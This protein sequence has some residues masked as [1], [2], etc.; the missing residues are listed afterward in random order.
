MNKI[1]TKL[2]IIW[3]SLLCPLFSM[4]SCSF[5][6]RTARK[7]LQEAQKHPYDIIVVP[8]VPFEKDTWSR[9]MKGRVYWSKYLFDQGIAK[10]IMYSGSSVYSPYFE[11]EIMALYAEALGI[12]KQY[13]Y[14]ETKAEHS[15]ENIYY[16]YRRSIQLGF[17]RIALASDPFQTKAL[18]KFTRKK[19]SADIGLIP[20][21]TDTLKAMEPQ[22][23]DPVIDYRQAY[24]K[25][26]VPLTEREG[27][28]K[29]LRGTRGLNIDTSA[30]K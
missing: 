3:P 20:M 7:L 21:T 18:R 25:D 10:N 5:S 17:H 27:F 14:T 30:Y 11:G 26:F 29:R 15:T 2:A 22:M 16:S 8:G 13:I 9:T 1:Y 24:N 23:T 19:I 12:P 28:W 6:Q 4:V